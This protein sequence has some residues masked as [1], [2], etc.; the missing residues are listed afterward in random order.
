[1]SFAETAAAGAV[2]QETRKQKVDTVFS[3]RQK[4]KMTVFELQCTFII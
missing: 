1:M 2:W 4:K 3:L